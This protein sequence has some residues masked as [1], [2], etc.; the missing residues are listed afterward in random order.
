MRTC[1]VVALLAVSTIAASAQ[2]AT[3]VS[4]SYPCE[5]FRKEA[6]GSWTQVKPIKV[7]N[8]TLTDISYD[9]G[10]KEALDLDKRCR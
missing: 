7:L 6:N 1:F 5:S 2:Q 8:V 4:A 10:S 3:P 9:K